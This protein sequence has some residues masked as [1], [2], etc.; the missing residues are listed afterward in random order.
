MELFLKKASYLLMHWH[1]FRDYAWS[2]VAPI[3]KNEQENQKNNK[4]V[5]VL[6]IILVIIL[7]VLCVLFATGTIS[8]KNSEVDNNIQDNIIDNKNYNGIID[9]LEEE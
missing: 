3:P 4:G 6:L 1:H 9:F 8:F 2:K 7:S 5:I